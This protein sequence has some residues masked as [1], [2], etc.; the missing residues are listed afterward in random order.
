MGE[1]GISMI[2]GPLYR[3]TTKAPATET[4]VPM[5]LAWLLEL[6]NASFSIL[7]NMKNRVR[8]LDV[9]NQDAKPRQWKPQQKQ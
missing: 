4:M 3:V 2:G 1:D 9:H 5:I 7:N 6:L 8:K